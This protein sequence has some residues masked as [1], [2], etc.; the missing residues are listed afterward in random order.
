MDQN[1][2]TNGTGSDKRN[3]RNALGISAKELP[4]ISDEFKAAQP[5]APEK[6]AVKTQP[7]TKPAPMAPRASPARSE[8]QE[9]AP[10][11]QAQNAGSPPSPLAEAGPSGPR[12]KSWPNSGSTRRANGLR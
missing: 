6:I 4:R 3:W 12:L 9:A 10:R 7:V 11:P 5:P 2:P 1:T 8:T